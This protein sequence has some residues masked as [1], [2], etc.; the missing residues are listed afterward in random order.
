[1]AVI[2]GVPPTSAL[3]TGPAR[4]SGAA[5]ATT[6]SLAEQP[7][8]ISLTLNDRALPYR[9]I[10]IN[11]RQRAEF[12]WYPG[13]P[14]ATVQMLGPEE[15]VISLRGFWK[16]RFLAGTNNAIVLGA[17]SPPSLSPTD[18]V[19]D[20]VRLVDQMRRRGKLICLS[21]DTLIRYGHITSFTQTWHNHHDCEWEME[22]SVISQE[23]PAKKVTS[24][25]FTAPD[26]ASL[27]IAADTQSRRVTVVNIEGLWGDKP[28]TEPSVTPTGVDG[29]F[30]VVP[31]IKQEPPPWWQGWSD[32]VGLA[33]TVRGA[34]GYMEFVAN[35]WAN[36][37]GNVAHQALY[38][39]QTPS[40]LG[41]NVLNSITG[42]AA[43]LFRSAGTLLDGALTEYYTYAEVA[44]VVQQDSMPFG[45]QLGQKSYL[46]RLKAAALDI[47][48]SN[49]VWRSQYT[50]EMANTTVRTFVAPADMDLRDVCVLFYGT[51][52]GWIELMLYNGLVVSRIPAGFVVRV[53]ER[54]EGAP[55]GRT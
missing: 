41:R 35:E 29:V 20:L 5:P 42:P 50:E 51:Q 3:P 32:F 38:L 30:V 10:S 37:I 45:I 52:D 44:N 33:E 25:A 47:R 53:P 40:E 11:G 34:G 54:L 9:P 21:W 8:G 7:S 43:T 27:W 2:T 22:F 15:G 6:F 23:D 24:K 46:A 55:A 12:T 36:D 39:V 17:S 48:T 4:I 19:A 31:P 13:S 28:A 14:N 49:A 26:V 16:D 18:T 1:M